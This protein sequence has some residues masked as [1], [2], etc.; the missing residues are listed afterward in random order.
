MDQR[1]VP[2]YL[3]LIRLAGGLADRLGMGLYLVGGMVRDLLLGQSNFDIDLV[4]EGDAP[5][6]TGLLAQHAGGEV[7]T[8][9]RFGTAKF[10]RGDLSM[11]LATARSE[12]YARPGALPTVQPGLIGGDLSRRDF[13][14]N[15]MAVHLDLAGFGDLLDPF[16]G[17]KD[18]AG[19]MIRALHD[20]SFVDD[21]TRM[22]RAVRYEQ[23]FDFRLEP[24]TEQMLRR[25]ISMLHTISGDRIR[26]EI[27]LILK[28]RAPEKPLGRAAE[29]GLLQ[30]IHPSLRGNGWIA[31]KFQEVRPAGQSPP[32]GLYLSLLVYHFSRE[33]GEDLLTRLRVPGATARVIRHTLSLKDNLGG[34]EDPHMSPAAVYNLLKDCSP[35]SAMACAVATD[36][37]VIRDRINLYLNRLRHVR[38]SLDGTAIQGE[39]EVA[40]GPRLGEILKM[41][42]EAKLEQRVS[43]RLEEMDLVRKWLSGGG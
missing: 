13:T 31:R 12:T 8:H 18:L 32:L 2:E 16:G 25:D 20:G 3:S 26:H 41:L 19:K 17:E 15:A 36:S 43:T 9:H 34:L 11:D 28:E 38:T 7:V 23:R 10:R 35:T 42:H 30:A 5:V 39:F 4:V 21:A 29:L 1:L 14:I 27:E 22:L 37:P 6:L 33:E 24:A 40:P